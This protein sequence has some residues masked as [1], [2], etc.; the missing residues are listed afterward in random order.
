[1]RSPRSLPPGP[2]A[3]LG[4]GAGV[5]GLVLLLAAAHLLPAATSNTGHFQTPLPVAVLGIIQGMTYGLLAIGLVLIYRSNRII[6]FAHGQIGVFAAAFFALAAT[7]WHVPYWVDLPVSLAVGAAVATVA[8]TAV[9]RRLRQAPRL[10]S[11]VATLGVGQFLGLLA[12]AINGSVGAGA[13]FP[14]PPGM[15]TFAVGALVVTPAYSGMLFLSPLVALGL[16][17]FLRRSRYGLGI[18]SA[19]ANPEA[20]RMAGIF[21]GRMSSLSW[22]LAGGLSALTAILTLP[23]QS[24]SGAESFGPNLLLRALTA[25]AVARMTSLPIALLAGLGVGV[26][27]QMLL[28][29]YPQSGLVELVLFMLTVVALLLQRTRSDRTESSVSSW[30]AVQ[31]LRPIPK[32]LRSLWPVRSLGLAT[33][34]VAL[35]VAVILPTV[36]SNSASTIL[37]GVFAFAIVGLSVGLLTGLA[38]QLTLGQFAVAAVGGVTSYYISRDT[39]NFILSFFCAGLF[40]G[41]VS[42]LLGLPALRSRGLLLTVTTLSFALV[43]PDWLLA[44]PWALGNGVDPGQPVLL[45]HALDTGRSFYYFALAV[46]LLATLLARNVRRGGFGQLLV[47]IRDNEDNARAFTVSAARVKLQ[48]YLVAGFIAGIGGATYT[49]SLSLVDA[50]AFPT[51]AS[52][53]V[54]VMTVIG[55]VSL[56]AGPLLGAL[57]VIALPAFVPLDSAGLVTSAL[58]QLLIILYVPRG[59]A[60]VVEPLRDRIVGYLGRRA[61]LD[62]AAAGPTPTPTAE[63]TRALEVR[64]IQ[65]MPI[66]GVVG[67]DAGATLLQAIDLSK[68]F[69]GVTAVDGVTFDVRTHETV[70]L[71][72]PNGAGKTTTFELLGGFTRLDTGAVHF[73]GRDI[74][75]LRPEQRGRLGLIRS[76]Q[77]AALFPTMTVHE[78]VMLSLERRTPTR[79]VRSVLGLPDRRRDKDR[80]ARDLLG[81]MGLGS[82]QDKQ[83]R[84]LS[85]GTRRITE[86]A[87]LVG[88]EP[89]LLLLDE[90]SSGIAQSETEALGRLLRELASTLDVT[91][92]VIE[93]DIPLIMGLADR[94]IA[95]DAGKVI[96][97]GP[98]HVVR[99]DPRVISSYLGAKFTPHGHSPHRA[100]AANASTAQADG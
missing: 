88:L 16:A 43:V 97:D 99:A 94:I 48:G 44:Q 46:L 17:V 33:G 10:M 3:V 6:N 63:V 96:A 50:S 26:V 69:G 13:L 77:D 47:A 86:L 7:R 57:F 55:G 21:A 79:P 2:R 42:V 51:S 49:H 95:M 12:F 68:H 53:D 36:I 19:S 93:H 45:G 67:R 29:N 87:C 40:A 52:I 56:L 38:G 71:I 39:G 81:T 11:V 34:L 37:T 8:E 82:Y 65:D 15:P 54:V 61:G 59:I 75:R 27:E 70:G 66:S 84:E 60:Q 83:I 28:W 9:V 98:P 73:G 22:A 62:H 4:A 1:M 25:A 80:Q 20:A 35:S 5:A 76:F 30:T 78:A 58:G 31:A 32:E 89:V 72:G 92:I 85:T 41:A 64:D 91:M 90:P 14:E 100:T 74:T 18:R 23:T 24:F